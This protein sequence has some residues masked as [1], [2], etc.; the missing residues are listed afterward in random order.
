M[1]KNETLISWNAQIIM[2]EDGNAG[3]A[4]LGLFVDESTGSH[5]RGGF[6][7]PISQSVSSVS[8]HYVNVE[9]IVKTQEA[10]KP[11]VFGVGLWRYS[12]FPV[13]D[14]DELA[15]LHRKANLIYVDFFLK[16]T[17]PPPA[18][19]SL[20]SRLAIPVE[21]A[22]AE[23]HGFDVFRCSSTGHLVAMPRI[24]ANGFVSP[25]YRYA[26]LKSSVSRLA[27]SFEALVET[28]TGDYLICLDLTYPQ[29][30]SKRLLDK[31]LFSST[32]SD[33]EKC[34]KRFIRLVEEHLFGGD[35]LCV[36]YNTHLWATKAPYKPHLH[37][38]LNIPNVLKTKDG[39]LVRFKPFLSRER[40]FLLR[41]LWFQAVRETFG[42]VSLASV[43]D[44]HIHYIPLRN[45]P[46]LVHRL[47]YCSRRP[48][49]DF[50]Y[51]YKEDVCPFENLEFVLRILSYQNH[52]RHLGW[53][54]GNFPDLKEARS[55]M[56]NVCRCPI[57]HA[58]AEKVEL[59]DFS[60]FVLVFWNGC[61]WCVKPPPC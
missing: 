34:V 43:Y 45:R 28:N 40:Y 8:V 48:S 18:F 57:C 4:P 60:R 21:Q 26:S 1:A 31:N 25:A 50:F 54:I 9:P 10:I 5:P 20:L 46:R 49:T 58:P 14:H 13:L 7:C 30:V 27:S 44:T 53:N 12:S 32:I 55:R 38:H 29:E 3:S 17:S 47:K 22:T 41:K 35:K 56:V 42:A 59:V 16:W 33:A 52:R 61:G 2:P 19:A 11:I 15:K 37:H 23:W 6:D 24:S 39:R 36:H 51:H